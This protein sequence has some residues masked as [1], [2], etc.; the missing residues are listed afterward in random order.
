MTCGKSRNGIRGRPVSEARTEV[1]IAVGV[2]AGQVEQIHAREDDEKSTEERNRIHSGR[3][4][5]ALEEE[6][7]GDECACCKGN[8]VERV[9]TGAMSD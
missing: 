8:I 7:R 1:R 5:E 6:A 3:R 2:F 4:I 9:Y